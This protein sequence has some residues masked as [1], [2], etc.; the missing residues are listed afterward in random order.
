MLLNFHLCRNI[1][2]D[3]RSSRN[4]LRARLYRQE[5]LQFR[6]KGHLSPIIACRL[7]WLLLNTIRGNNDSCSFSLSGQPRKLRRHGDRGWR[8]WRRR[9]WVWWCYRPR[10]YWRSICRAYMQF[11]VVQMN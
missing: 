2:V 4:Y 1:A 6:M 10:S 5:A 3:F 11:S 7:S 8:G 9:R